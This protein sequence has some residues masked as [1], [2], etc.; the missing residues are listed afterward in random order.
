MG[1]MHDQP[2]RPHTFIEPGGH[3]RAKTVLS[4]LRWGV[5]VRFSRLCVFTGIHVC[6][7]PLSIYHQLFIFAY[8]VSYR[9]KDTYTLQI[10]KCVLTTLREISTWSL[11]SLP[12]TR[13]YLHL[14]RLAE[15]TLNLLHDLWLQLRNPSLHSVLFHPHFSFC[16]PASLLPCFISSPSLSSSA[17][18]QH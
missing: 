5:Y 15:E 3:T 9:H 7:K 17:L 18:H 12:G 10:D 13:F 2:A 14:L 11:G 1:I 16:S 4:S 8:Q 6:C